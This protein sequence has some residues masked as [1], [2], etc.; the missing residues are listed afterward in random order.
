MGQCQLIMFSLICSM[1]YTLFAE[2]KHHK[3]FIGIVLILVQCQWIVY[4]IQF[5][6]GTRHWNV[7]WDEFAKYWFIVDTICSECYTCVYII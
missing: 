5:S 1:T 4:D 2:T 3:Q 7:Q 6:F